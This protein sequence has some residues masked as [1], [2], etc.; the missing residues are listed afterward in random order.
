M[1]LLEGKNAIITGASRGIGRGIAQVFAKHGANVAFTYS[2]SVEA[3]EEL[4]QELTNM[5]VK[6]KAY[7]SNAASF[8]EAQ[9]L[10]ANVSKDFSSIDILINN[11]GITKDNLLMRMSEEDF[12]K[13]IEVNL[14]SIFNMTKAV[15]R[16]MLKQRHG[17]IINMS[18]V[19]GVKGNAGQSNYAASKAGIIGFSKS[20]ALEL[21]SRNIRTNVIAPGFIETE[22]T[23]KLD[24]KTVQGWRDNIPLKRG[25]SPEDI[26]NACVFLGSDLSSYVTGQVI[27][28]DGGMLT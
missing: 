16:T 6:A 21:G 4:E 9:E 11:A 8:E 22:M 15:Q 20:M 18:S 25:G 1:K 27:N 5:G 26:A 24:E 23:A 12:D 7:K 10:I 19:V 3:A 13:V 28:V 17:S 2:S 14:K